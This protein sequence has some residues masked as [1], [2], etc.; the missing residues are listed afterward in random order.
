LEPDV[1]NYSQ[2]GTAEQWPQR[3]DGS[4]VSYVWLPTCY[5]LQSADPLMQGIPKAVTAYYPVPSSTPGV[6]FVFF[7]KLVAQSQ[8]AQW[9][10]ND[11]SSVVGAGNAPSAGSLA[12]GDCST[13]D[14]ISHEYKQVTSDADVTVTAQITYTLTWGYS[15]NGDPGQN[16]CVIS[17]L[18]GVSRNGYC[19]L[20]NG[21]TNPAPITVSVDP[22]DPTC[23]AGS[24]SQVCYPAGWRLHG[25]VYQI[26]GVPSA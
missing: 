25:P 17:V 13:S 5:A 11:G 4:W 16:Q 21:G 2:L 23:S 3:A 7:Y 19:D 8:G 6:D 14:P 18:G 12:A 15:W 10:F 20:S 1:V 24:G 9:H 26:E 22:S